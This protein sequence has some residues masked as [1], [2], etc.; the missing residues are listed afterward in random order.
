MRRGDVAEP[1]GRRATSDQG[2]V[3]HMRRSEPAIPGLSVYGRQFAGADTKERK[4]YPEE[5]SLK[6]QDLI[7]DRGRRR[8]ISN[9]VKP[10]QKAECHGTMRPQYNIIFCNR[11]GLSI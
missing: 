7:V 9:T 1:G 3:A 2:T 10:P 4:H 6:E 8:R 5:Q 11:L